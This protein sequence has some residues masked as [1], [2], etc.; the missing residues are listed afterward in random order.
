MF[1]RVRWPCSA[2][3]PA[4][5]PRLSRTVGPSIPFS[6]RLGQRGIAPFRARPRDEPRRQVEPVDGHVLHAV[7]I[8]QRLRVGAEHRPEGAGGRREAERAAGLGVH[9]RHRQRQVGRGEP[10]EPDAAALGEQLPDLDVVSLAGALL[11]AAP[12][13]AVEQPRLA[14]PLA[15]QRSDGALVGE[16]GVVVCEHGAEH[17]ARPV[18]AEDRSL[19]GL[20]SSVS[21]QAESWSGWR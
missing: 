21:R 4:S 2:R 11:V 6:L 16:L 7:R 18:G 19:L 10:V 15:E 1:R 5:L 13:V 17:A 14:R 20:C 12:R 3:R 9:V 8:Q